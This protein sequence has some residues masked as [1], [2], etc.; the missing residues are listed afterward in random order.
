[1]KE[2]FAK[3]VD[4]IRRSWSWLQV[5]LAHSRFFCNLCWNMK[6]RILGINMLNLGTVI[7]H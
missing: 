6:L 5:F 7:G 4:V 2:I 3:N 1:V